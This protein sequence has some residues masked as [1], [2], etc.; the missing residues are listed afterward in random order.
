MQYI[1]K[2]GELKRGLRFGVS[3]ICDAIN[4]YLQLIQPAEDKPMVIPL[5]E[6][7]YHI[8]TKLQITTERVEETIFTQQNRESVVNRF[9]AAGWTINFTDGVTPKLRMAVTPTYMQTDFQP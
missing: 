7:Y 8:A 6:L 3:D 5:V 9:T 4:F 1:L 2:P